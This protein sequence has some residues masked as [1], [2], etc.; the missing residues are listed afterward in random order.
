MS[1]ETTACHGP[2]RRTLRIKPTT[3]TDAA[4]CHHPQHLH[5]HDKKRVKRQVAS[6]LPTCA[7]P[8]G[9]NLTNQRLMGCSDDQIRLMLK[10]CRDPLKEVRMSCPL[11]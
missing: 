9:P 5:L 2:R 1:E 4:P 10:L 7:V 11:K 3:I 6:H 8:A